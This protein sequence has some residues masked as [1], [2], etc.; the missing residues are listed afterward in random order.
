MKRWDKQMTRGQSTSHLPA[1]PQHC[2]PTQAAVQGA[3]AGRE[4]SAITRAVTC[5][6][7]PASPL[8][9]LPLGKITVEWHHSAVT[10]GARC[11]PFFLK[12]PN[13]RRYVAVAS[14]CQELNRSNKGNYQETSKTQQL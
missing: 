8:P 4:V 9:P 1:F 11:K 7:G 10:E 2:A 13:Q 5:S 6:C 14:K 3:E 12:V